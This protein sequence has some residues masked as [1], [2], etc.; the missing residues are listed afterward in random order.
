M[1]YVCGV[2]EKARPMRVVHRVAT[3]F[4]CL[5]GCAELSLLELHQ[6][7]SANIIDGVVINST[8]KKLHLQGD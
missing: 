8:D 3:I 5:G 1:T 4:V 7:Q 2:L 6:R